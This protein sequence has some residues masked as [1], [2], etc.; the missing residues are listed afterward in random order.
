MVIII[1]LAHLLQF[2]NREIKP[3]SEE[4]FL[5]L[6]VK[7][8]ARRRRLLKRVESFDY[9]D[10]EAPSTFSQMAFRDETSCGVPDFG[11]STISSG[12]VDDGVQVMV[13]VD[14]RIRVIEGEQ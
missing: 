1:T 8:K 10:D 3:D 11:A 4:L 13:D 7:L 6:G 5:G 14:V 2:S 9:F 12:R